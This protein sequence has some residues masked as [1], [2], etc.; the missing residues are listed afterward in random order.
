MTVALCMV[1]IYPQLLSN[2]CQSWTHANIYNVHEILRATAVKILSAQPSICQKA[3]SIYA[4]VILCPS[5]ARHFTNRFIRHQEAMIAHRRVVVLYVH[6]A[7]V[8]MHI[9]TRPLPVLIDGQ[10]PYCLC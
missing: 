3:S 7:Q 6:A 5:C 1:V 4:I 10:L 2:L 9:V 8:I